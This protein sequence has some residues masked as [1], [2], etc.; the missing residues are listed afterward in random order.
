MNIIAV[1]R[2]AR[3]IVELSTPQGKPV[4]ERKCGRLFGSG[5]TCGCWL[6]KKPRIAGEK[7]PAGK[8]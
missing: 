3:G 6:S 7:C 4:E 5:K 2:V 8:W 1:D